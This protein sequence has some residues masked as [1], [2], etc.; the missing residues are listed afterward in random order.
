MMPTGPPPQM[1]T[2]T[3][4]FLLRI[5]ASVEPNYRILPGA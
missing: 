3:L 1:A 5:D 2:G 4:R